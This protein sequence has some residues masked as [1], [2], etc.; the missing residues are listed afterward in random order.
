MYERK[1]GFKKLLNNLFSGIS[2]DKMPP[3]FLNLLKKNTKHYTC[4]PKGNTKVFSFNLWQN[5]TVWVFQQ[6]IFHL[7][8]HEDFDF[9]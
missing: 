3:P 9:L 6:S 7:I 4:V 1:K 2:F 5:N 8:I